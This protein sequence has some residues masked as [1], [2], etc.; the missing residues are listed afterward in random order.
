MRHCILFYLLLASLISFAESEPPS[1]TAADQPEIRIG[2]LS[3]LGV[4]A[5]ARAWTPTAQYLS[6]AVNGMRFRILPLGFDTIESAVAGEKVDFLLVNPGI[7]V[8]LELSHGIARIATMRSGNEHNLFGGV[9]FARSERDDI[10]QLADLTGKRFMGVDALSLGGFEMAWAELLESGVAPDRDLAELRFAGTH[11]AVVAAVRDGQVDAG[12]VRTGTLER[13]AE[14]GAISLDDLRILNA[15][16]EPG[17]PFLLSTSLYPE[18]PFSRLSHTPDDL[19]QRVAVALLQMPSNGAAAHAGD[20]AGWTVPLDYQS[21][22]MLLQQ[23]G[24]APYDEQAPFTLR[25]ALSRYWVVVVAGLSALLVLLALTSRVLQLNQRLSR[26]NTRLE[27]RQQLILDSVAE[28]IFGVDL[29]DRATFVNKAMERMTGWRAEELIGNEQ[30]EIIHHTRIDG[31]PYP[32]EDCPVHATFRDNLPRFVEDDLFWRR[33]GSSFPVEYSTTP[34][35]DD[36]GETIGSVVVFRDITERRKAAERISRHE[37]EQAHFARLSTIGEMASGIAHELNQPL[38]AITTNARACVRMIETGRTSMA[39]CG[40]VMTKIAE[41]AERAGEVIRQ[42]RRFVRKEQPEIAK[43]AVADIFDTVLVLLRQD[44]R[45]ASVVLYQQLGAHADHVMAQRTQ[46][47]QVLLNLVRNAI[48]AMADQQRERR[49]LLIARRSGDQVEIRVVDTGPGLGR[50]SPEHLFEPFVT[51][52]AQGLGVGLSVSN[53]IV[54]AHG[55]KLRVDST[56]GIGATFFFSLPYA[57]EGQYE[58]RATA[59]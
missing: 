41:Q 51:T 4:D 12:T 56:T 31:E 54:E 40:D 13:M 26:A 17:F 10:E 28:G 59:T 20:Y 27:R 7:Y 55:G 9:I 33:D 43:V 57:G 32:R 37:A 35:R 16:S 53:G 38:T 29:K 1:T 49:V 34:I 18:W 2:I 52:K 23:L 58:A 39:S 36:V 6:D 48:E 42:I 22:H 30:H 50:G 25:D 8:G 47:E 15:R 44:A 14:S 3:H 24:R 46:I 5:T 19:A 45:R 11:D 21:V